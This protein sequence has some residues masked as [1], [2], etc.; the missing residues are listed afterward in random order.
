[1][2]ESAQFFNIAVKNSLLFSPL[3][4]SIAE[5]D[6]SLKPGAVRQYVDIAR[7]GV[8]VLLFQNTYVLR[9]GKTH[10]F[11]PGL[12]E[13]KHM[14]GLARLV[15]AVKKE[16]V[17]VGIR[18]GHAGAKTSERICGEQPVSPSSVKFG[19]DFDTSRAF[20]EEDSEE[21]VLAFVHAAERAQEVGMDF[22]ELNATGQF[23]LDQCF[24]RK[25]NHR[26]DEYGTSSVLTRLCL[27]LR[28]ISAIKTRDSITI[29]LSYYFQVLEKF[30]EG[31]SMDEIEHMIHLLGEHGIDI[32]HPL[33]AHVTNCFPESPTPLIEWV[34]EVS[35]GLV[36]A[37]GAIKSLQALTDASLMKHAEW[38]SMDQLMLSRPQWYS[39]LY[40][41]F[42]PSTDDA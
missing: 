4:G 27:P 19:R 37:E 5:A 32:F 8:G 31:F 25:Y 39:F 40:K 7:Q 38:F 14:E 22:I 30:E 11:Q 29:P 17:A 13:E 28:I 41:K 33:L 21:I 3:S 26:E 42:K 36:I 20:D 35:N 15:R 10:P 1:M 12:S 24:S 2:F 16:G 6:G 9:Q 18:L 34:G 23:L